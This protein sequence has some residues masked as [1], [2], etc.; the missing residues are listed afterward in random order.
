MESNEEKP[1]K[2]FLKRGYKIALGLFIF[3]ILLPALLTWILVTF[4]A[5][6]IKNQIAQKI[7]TYLAVPIDVKEI[8]FTVWKTFPLASLDFKEIKIYDALQKNKEKTF[9]E[10]E[11][12]YLSFN[13]LDIINKSYKVKACSVDDAK[14]NLRFNNKGEGNYKFWKESNAPDT[15]FFKLHLKD[16]KGS[17]VDFS[18]N[19]PA[20]KQSYR[21]FFDEINLNGTFGQQSYT[22]AVNTQ[23]Y[24]KMFVVGGINYIEQK[25]I[26]LAL[27][28][29]VTNNKK[30]V[31][32]VGDLI[33][34]K[35]P[36]SIQ[37]TV[38]NNDD[39]VDID[40][41][42][43]EHHAEVN[44]LL[45]LLPQNLQAKLNDY[46]GKGNIKV[47]V[48]IKG[49]INDEQAPDI[50]ALF[51]LK[52]ASFNYKDVALTNIHIA[53]NY[54]NG[55][56]QA[57][58]TSVLVL[59]NF[60]AYFQNQPIRGSITIANFDTPTAHGNLEGNVNLTSLNTFL[61]FNEIENLTGN[62]DFNFNFSWPLHGAQEKKRLLTEYKT[63][64]FLKL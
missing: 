52:E 26:H 8:D 3:L 9:L 21:L 63:E 14:I 34:A 16:I 29:A 64:G 61:K 56:K 36:F 15:S 40:L 31:I 5:D 45:S 62:A 49:K 42:V 12:L 59:K 60:T 17:K 35:V 47:A 4:Y 20:K 1:K 25:N 23:A 37:G 27:K 11:H 28:L 55:T 22:L 2:L 48:N 43:N 24:V 7:N 6:E 10:A 54:S 39:Y 19:Y 44:Q 58:S 32:K 50:N 30:F 33:L 46:K 51:D 13:L 41:K 38:T 18:F 57:N 53:G